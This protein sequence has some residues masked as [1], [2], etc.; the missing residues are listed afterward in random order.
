M[1]ETKDLFKKKLQITEERNRRR[2]QKMEK[3]LM[4]M[5]W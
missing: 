4:L 2:Y 1:K 5:D 3:S